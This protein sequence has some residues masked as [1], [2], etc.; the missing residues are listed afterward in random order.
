[1]SLARLADWNSAKKLRD[2]GPKSPKAS[3]DPMDPKLF[4]FGGDWFSDA[5]PSSSKHKVV[6]T[7]EQKKQFL[8]QLAKHEN[9]L[10]LKKSCTPKKPCSFSYF[11]CSPH[12][13]RCSMQSAK[14]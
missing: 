10:K 14:K 6:M 5:P 7:E 8:Y 12:C 1:M 3:S 2:K 13:E 9:W 4:G 11:S